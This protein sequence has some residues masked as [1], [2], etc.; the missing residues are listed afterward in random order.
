MSTRVV[1]LIGLALLLAGL[2]IS[3]P[4]ARAQ[5]TNAGSISGTIKDSSGAVVPDATVTI[6]NT[7]T[8][9][10]RKITSDSVGG[11]TLQELQ[12]GVYDITVEKSGFKKYVDTAVT[13]HLNDQLNLTVELQA[14][15]ITETVNVTSEVPLV[16]SEGSQLD[17]NIT[18][19]MV[20][21]L[22]NVNRNFISLSQLA[23][24]YLRAAAQYSALVDSRL[25][26]FPRTEGVPHK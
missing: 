7:A 16:E 13:L 12:V 2:G 23:P 18:G 26:P 20:R 5:A 15:S 17:T 4:K 1:K 21:E 25:R 9:Q 8:S 3:P 24:G 10:S 11:F 19:E 14:G 22:P 6:T